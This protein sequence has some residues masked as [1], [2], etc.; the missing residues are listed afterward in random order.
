MVYAKSCFNKARTTPHG[1][2]RIWLYLAASVLLLLTNA[3]SAAHRSADQAV[4]VASGFARRGDA[5]RSHRARHAWHGMR[6]RGMPTGRT[7]TYSEGGSALFHLVELDG[8]G[9]VA[10]SAEGGGDPVLGFSP[11]GTMPDESPS[12]PFWALAARTARAAALSA[13][14][15]TKITSESALDDVRVSPLVQSKWDQMAA[16]GKNT[17][18]LYTPNNWHCGC[19]ATAMA[20]LMRFHRYPTAPIA[21][22]TFMCYTN[23]VAV[24]LT[25]K[26]GTYEWESMPYA[27]GSAAS[28]AEREAIGKICYDA[29]VAMRMDY[30][31]N[32]SGAFGEA[33]AMVMKDVFGFA[34]AQYAKPGDSDDF[35]A[36]VQDAILTNLDAGYPVILGIATANNA[37]HAILA[38]GYGYFDG[39]LFCHLNMGWSGSSDYWYALPTITTD[40]YNFTILD[41]IAYNLFPDFSGEIA[42]G[43]VVDPSGKPI[44]GAT[45]SATITCRRRQKT[46]TTS[47]TDT[48]DGNGIFSVVAPAGVSSTVSLAAARDGWTTA[49]ATTNVTA[50]VS[51]KGVS[52]GDDGNLYADSWTT[53]AGSRW[54]NDIV[55]GSYSGE[56]AAIG[57]FAKMP[58]SN[59]SGSLVWNLAFAGTP[60]AWYVVEQSETLTN[61]T[62]TVCTNAIL[63]S[64][65][66]LRIEIQ[67]DAS[68]PSMFYRARPVNGQ[69]D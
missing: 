45:V 44:V 28:D 61:K 46:E 37:G 41:G 30:T 66:T 65:G 33:I 16:G 13:A 24:E 51:P 6:P 19:V 18:N 49:A 38:D 26:G 7:R 50:S 68:V 11:S 55:F 62:W 36:T 2:G 14:S 48:T 69:S 27:P 53:S 9:F 47:A 35:A 3:A 21:P 22:Q 64:T 67:S 12:N 56:D 1:A 31:P 59:G 17:Y 42:S 8:G 60:G 43:R 15:S 52:F 25:M 4:V 5:K 39:T 34:N 40:Y 57:S 20:Q 63:P 58:S 32:G 54:G 29:G 10:V 23:E